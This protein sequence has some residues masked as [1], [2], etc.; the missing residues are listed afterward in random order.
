MADHP[1]ETSETSPGN[2]VTVPRA[3]PADVIVRSD[4]PQWTSWNWEVPESASAY[5]IEVRSS[6]EDD[7]RFSVY[8]PRLPG[9][10]SEGDTEEHAIANM[11]DAVGELLRTYRDE[12]MPIPWRQEGDVK[13]PGSGERSKWILVSV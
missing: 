8:A 1:H 9:A 3:D 4:A 13:P 10:H 7:G 5:Q 2:V 11:S 6:P 12:K